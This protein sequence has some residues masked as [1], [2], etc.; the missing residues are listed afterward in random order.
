MNLF[1][2][3]N[4]YAKLNENFFAEVMPSASENPELI[5]LNECL[6][7]DLNIDLSSLEKNEIAAL[8]SGNK[9]STGA[10]PLAM[11][12]A[13]HQFGH[14]TMLGDGRAILLG[15]H[16]SSSG[17]RYDI[18]LKGSGRTPFSRGGDGRATLRAMLREYLMSECMHALGVPTSRSL[19][20]VKTGLSVSREA[21]HEGA[22]LTRV[23]DS[24]LR[25]GTFEYARQFLSI[26]EQKEL[27]DYT[28][29]R[30]FPEILAQENRALEFLKAVQQQQ[31]TLIVN[32]MRIGF[33][34]GVMNTD[35]MH[36]GGQTFDYGPCAFM[37]SYD[38][39]TVFSSIDSNGRY[40]YSNQPEIALWN[41]SVL[42]GTILPQIHE[43][44]EIAVALA[45][46]TLNEFAENYKSAWRKMMCSK[47]GL[48][49]VNG[50]ALLLLDRLLNWMENTKSDYTNTFLVLSDQLPQSKII[51]IDDTIKHWIGDWK[52]HIKQSSSWE[53][54]LNQMKNN[55]PLAIPRNHLVEK[56]L[57]RATEQNDLTFFSEIIA[58]VK[59]PD[60]IKNIND[61]QFVLEGSD[62][63]YQTF[64]G[65]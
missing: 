14:F 59:S 28:V 65:T 61:F 16:L 57:D 64:C 4:T 33:I 12:Y 54:A 50:P 20:V 63:G 7:R 58:A 47:I 55:N 39:K 8:L 6:A 30:H 17:K 40:A 48:E 31:V 60:S 41:L 13:G 25:V 2:F 24:H 46:E 18:Q 22:V 56:A 53:K 9:L 32:W 10:Q 37:N 15:E 45:R 3:D 38:P 35:N 42:A 44:Q 34:H 5:V 43:N 62:Y 26:E 1:N 36:I 29:K 52:N 49:E 11:A 19:A 21:I 27:L 23:M 51:I